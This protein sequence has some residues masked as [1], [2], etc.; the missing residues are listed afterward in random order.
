MEAL[1]LDLSSHYT[2]AANGQAPLNPSS[3]DTP[4]A[5][6]QAPPTDPL[7]PSGSL[8][9]DP[10][11]PNPNPNANP[12]GVPCA[13]PCATLGHGLRGPVVEHAFWGTGAVV[14]LLQVKDGEGLR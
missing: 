5:N 6:G 10:P 3:N 8:P 13:W 9:T 14:E 11:S 2:P 4:A 12:N 1:L 7:S